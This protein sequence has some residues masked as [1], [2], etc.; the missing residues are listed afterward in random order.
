MKGLWAKARKFFSMPPRDMWIRLGAE[1]GPILDKSVPGQREERL[2][3]KTLLKL[4]GVNSLA[5]LHE[6]LLHR[7]MPWRSG[8]VTEELL[9]THASGSSELIIE[10]AEAAMA[11]WV[12]LMGSGPVN[13][14]DPGETA[15]HR[16]YAS[17]LSWPFDYFHE[18]NPADLDRASDVKFPWE[19]SRMQWLIPVAQAWHLTKND[20]YASYIRQVLEHWMAQNPCSWGINWG[21][22]M[23]PAMRII[24]WCW[25]YQMLADAPSWRDSAFRFSFIRTLY[26]HLQFVRRYV[27]ITDVNGNHLTAD[28]AALVV[29][30]AF[31]GGKTA[32]LW[33]AEGWRILKREIFLQVYEDGVDFEGSVPYHRLVAELFHVSA[34]AEHENAGVVPQAYQ[35]RLLRM[36]DYTESYTRPDGLAPVWGD[37][38]DARTLPMGNQAIGD[39][40]YLPSLI[41]AYWSPG[42]LTLGWLDAADECLWWWGKTP[43]DSKPETERQSCRF[44]NG[45]SYI[46]RSEGDYVFF[47]CGPLGLANRG[48]HGHND[49]L[50]FEAVLEGIP[51]VVDPGCPVYTGDWQLRNEYRATAQ[52][53]TIQI[54]ENEINRFISPRNMWFLHGDARATLLTWSNTEQVSIVGGLHTGYQR[55]SPPAAVQRVLLLDKAAHSL[56]WMDQVSGVADRSVSVTLQ[57]A[58]FVDVLEKRDGALLLKAQG[59]RFVLDFSD[60]VDWDVSFER[61]HVAPQYGVRV[62]AYRVIWRLF[63]DQDQAKLLVSMYPGEDLSPTFR[64]A[65]KMAFMQNDAA[66]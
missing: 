49:M 46:L 65:A 63:S 60:S 1:L 28:A 2:D 11:G 16:D 45:G 24:T 21:C 51:L 4:L 9:G 15:W 48:G 18:L 26:L 31:L 38:D 34:C 58:P 13:I 53:S 5:V 8:A 42:A 55:L 37:N 17:G 29:G 12:C 7:A 61:A 23:E 35:Q 54:D 52:H 32:T 47:D 36:A 56:A 10:R 62:A 40:R 3:Q 39:H 19:L 43:K 66:H 30:G 44:E 14:G 41:R 59:K 27:E 64:D 57:L 50:A 22:T 25:F 6:D 33:R 20:R